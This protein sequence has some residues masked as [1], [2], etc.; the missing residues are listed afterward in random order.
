MIFETYRARN[1]STARMSNS[2][3][4]IFFKHSH[5]FTKTASCIRVAFYPKSLDTLIFN[6]GGG[7]DVRPDNVLVNYS[8]SLIRFSKVQL[9]DCGGTYTTANPLDEGHII[10]ATILRSPEAMLHLPQSDI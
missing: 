3:L 2:C 4:E 5:H 6:D 10:G 7:T 8:D 1:D 9:C